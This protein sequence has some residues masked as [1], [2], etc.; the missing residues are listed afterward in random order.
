MNKKEKKDHTLEFSYHKDFDCFFW[1]E[2][3]M[4]FSAI[5]R[6]HFLK[7]KNK[8]EELNAIIKEWVI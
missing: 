5:Q 3:N 1:E 7:A 8:K 4:P 2:G 6:T